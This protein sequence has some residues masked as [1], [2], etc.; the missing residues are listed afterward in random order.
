MSAILLKFRVG[1][2]VRCHANCTHTPEVHDCLEGTLLHEDARKNGWWRMQHAAGVSIVHEQE[3]TT[4]QRKPQKR[5]A[6]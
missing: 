4:P 2:T 1:Q 3:L 5:R 6:G